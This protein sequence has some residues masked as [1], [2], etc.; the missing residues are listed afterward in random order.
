MCR[1]LFNW[2]QEARCQDLS[3]IYADYLALRDSWY[4]SC[5]P[6]PRRTMQ[7]HSD[8]VAWRL[9]IRKGVDDPGVSFN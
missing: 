4:Y 6:G 8:R 5:V 3:D 7:A 2:A 9:S 1:P